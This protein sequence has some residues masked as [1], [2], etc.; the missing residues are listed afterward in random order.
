MEGSPEAAKSL[1]ALSFLALGES[2][3]L[4]DVSPLRLDHELELVWLEQ[5]IVPELEREVRGFLQLLSEVP[6]LFEHIHRDVG[7]QLHQQ[8]VA[9][10]FHR[11][12]LHGPLHPAHD[13]FRCQD[14][15]CSVA[16]LTGLS[17]ALIVALTNALACHLDQPEVADG[18]RLRARAVARQMLPEL[19]EDTVTVRLRLHVDEVT[20]DDSADVAQPELAGNFLRS[21]D[22]GLRSEE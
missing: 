21:L 6:L 14:A 16:H 12:S 2:V 3:L 10:A 11:H 15:P 8:I 18:E 7:M 22:S 1:V 4:G 19:L 13:G 5:R 17:R 20:D 9:P